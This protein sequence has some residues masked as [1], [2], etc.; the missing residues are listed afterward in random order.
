MSR[1]YGSLLSISGKDE[2]KVWMKIEYGHLF[3]ETEHMTGDLKGADW[4]RSRRP[5]TMLSGSPYKPGAGGDG[6]Q[7]K[8]RSSDH[9]KEPGWHH[10]QPQWH[11]GAQQPRWY[12]HWQGAQQLGANVEPPSFPFFSSLSAKLCPS[13][14]RARIGW[15]GGFQTVW[16][17]EP[18]ISCLK[19]LR[20]CH[21]QRCWLSMSEIFQTAFAF[22]ICNGNVFKF[23]PH[24]GISRSTCVLDALAPGGVVDSQKFND[25]M[26]C[27]RRFPIQKPFK[28]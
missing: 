13:Q 27:W 2:V 3:L 5:R 20:T 10:E 25:C 21:C 6:P 17:G 7:C 26:V 24:S 19:M 22:P 11:Q 18:T 28:D 1:I 16:I 14:Q 8:C 23:S 12:Q 15:Q 9:I 4:A